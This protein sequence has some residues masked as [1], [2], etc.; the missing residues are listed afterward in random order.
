MKNLKTYCL[1]LDLVSDPNLI[2]EYKKQHQNVWPEIIESIKSSGI[3][4]MEI[5]QLENR[6]FM[7]IRASE[8]FDFSKKAKSDKK[9]PAVQ[10]W[11]NLMWQ[12]QQAIP[13]SKP[14]EKWRLMD[15]I[16]DLKKAI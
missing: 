5:Y 11:E 9:N 13:G 3:E 15:K 8:S 14:G 4:Q 2:D 10:K 6:L 16:F 7:I 1:T 12:Y